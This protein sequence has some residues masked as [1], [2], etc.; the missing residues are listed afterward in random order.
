MRDDD[1]AHVSTDLEMTT[2][3]QNEENWVDWEFIYVNDLSMIL[4]VYC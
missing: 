3:R 4:M 2:A 1:T